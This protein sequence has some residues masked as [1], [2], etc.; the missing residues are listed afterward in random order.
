MDKGKILAEGSLK[1]LLSKHVK[2]E[3][4]SFATNGHLTPNQIP[5]NGKVLKMVY[6]E[7]DHHGEI[8]VED[9]VNY[10]PQFLDLVKASGLQLTSLEC[11]KMTLDDLFIAMTG[12]H[13]NE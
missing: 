7:D 8:I 1:D 6:N 10:L 13:I 11:R 2:G 3:V 5:Q 4:I 12:R 9:L